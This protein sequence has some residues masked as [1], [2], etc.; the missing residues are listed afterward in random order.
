MTRFTGRKFD[1]WQ[2]SLSLDE[3][4]NWQNAVQSRRR[5]QVWS[6]LVPESDDQVFRRRDD[7]A[8]KIH[9]GVQVAMIAF[10]HD[11]AMQNFF[12]LAQIDHVTALRIRL[13]AHRHLEHVIMPVPVRVG[14]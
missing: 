14:A 1:T 6:D 3:P 5:R 11:R 4:N 2:S 13:A 7:S 10:V 8:Q 12:Q 9:I